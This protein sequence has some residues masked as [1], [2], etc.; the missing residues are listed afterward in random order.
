MAILDSVQKTYKKQFKLF[1][2]NIINNKVILTVL[3]NGKKHNVNFDT[4][5]SITPLFVSDQKL[6]NE[7]TDISL[8]SDTLRE[9]NSWGKTYDNIYGAAIKKNLIIGEKD[10]GHQMVYY[11]DS[12]YHRNLFQQDSI[13]ALLGSIVFFQEEILIDF[14]NQ[15]MGL[16]SIK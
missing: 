14:K 15:K 6:Y 5:S 9:F 2:F 12:E 1:D 16:K 3:I 13:V 10:F 7:I 4:G 11:L 8:A